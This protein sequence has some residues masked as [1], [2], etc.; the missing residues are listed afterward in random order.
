MFGAEAEP[1]EQQEDT[2]A[3]YRSKP[4]SNLQSRLIGRLHPQP[5]QT[6]EEVMREGPIRDPRIGIDSPARNK[7]RKHERTYYRGSK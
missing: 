4:L 3:N 1:A 5:V 6:F 7:Q 2:A